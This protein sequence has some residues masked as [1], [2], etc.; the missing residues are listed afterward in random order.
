V[1]FARVL[2]ELTG[3][4]ADHELRWAVIGGVAMAA[5]GLAR[6]TLD[7]D[8]VAERSAQEAIVRH[9]EAQGYRTLYRSEGYSNHQHDDAERG[10]VDFAYV[11]GETAQ[12]LFAQVRQVS[13]PG[14]SAIQVPSPEHVAAMKV[15][16]MANDTTRKDHELADLRFLLALPDIDREAVRE[17]F[18]RRGKEDEWD[19]LAPKS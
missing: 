17:Q 1:D 19:D 13:G 6:T 18:V 8:F 10:R 12:R 3:F 5:Y 9:L 15:H 2:D 16:A 7:L 14:G 4:F 11:S